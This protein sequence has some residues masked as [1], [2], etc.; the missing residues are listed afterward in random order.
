MITHWN[1]VFITF[2][3]AACGALLISSAAWAESPP[4]AGR[5]LEETQKTL[6]PKLPEKPGVQ[7]PVPQ[8]PAMKER[9]EAKI[10]V[11]S[12]VFSMDFPVVPE[13]E[14]QQIVKDYINR[15]VTFGE[16]EEAAGKVTAYLRKKGYFLARA[17]I[18]QQDIIDGI[19]KINVIIGKAEAGKDGKIV[20]VEGEPKRLKE[21]VVQGI[22]DGTVKAGEPLELGRLERGILLINDLPGITASTNLS[23][24]S[25]P[26]TTR[27]AVKLKEGPVIT[28]SAGF[29]NFGNRYTGRERFLGNFNINDLTGYG[30]TITLTGLQA[31]EP[32]FNI[33]KGKMWLWRAGWL[34]PIGHS[35]LQAGVAY[36]SLGYRTGE[37]TANLD[38]HGT[39]RTWAANASYPIIRSRENNLYT[40]IM[41][42]HK[43]LFDT[44]VASVID[45]KRVNVITM[46]LNG[47]VLDTFGGGGY[48]AYGV[49][50]K[51]GQLDLGKDPEDLAVDQQTLKTDGNYWKL[52]YNVERQ[53]N[54]GSGFTLY[55]M[56]TGQYAGKNL[57]TS[58]Q[59]TLGGPTGVRAYAA[60]EA[61]GDNEVLM[62]M[63]LRKDFPGSTPLG[64]IQVLAFFDSGWVA[65][66]K[67]TWAN[68]NS[69]N[70]VLSNSY[71]L[72]GA[73]AGVNIS[74][75]SLYVIKAFW[76]ATIGSNP[77]L[78]ASGLDSEGRRH[79]NRFWVQGVAY[80]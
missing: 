60:G 48:T 50:V 20:E 22:M 78:S 18:P 28:G 13:P 26:G 42:E 19:V 71:G 1:S 5:L 24:G 56:L 32:V 16:L 58:E 14:L 45:D 34:V 53:Q 57:D 39:A 68:W 37:E 21:S 15:E 44:T 51:G 35:G 40:S 36:T 69:I 4:D 70:P 11:K 47:N 74:R 30:D 61:P 73:G 67:N 29:D 76:A 64:H 2:A 25:T 46:G 65:L 38:S 59:M 79:D 77:G 49:S 80:F 54:M 3:A 62:N 6:P 75:T 41:Y 12:F 10:F 66:H 52:N 7:M 27:I 9:N 55:G 31:G 72:S 8:E 33:N 17:Y 43:N 23:A 63:E